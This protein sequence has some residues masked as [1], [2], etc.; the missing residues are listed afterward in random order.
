MAAD[1][2]NLE[3]FLKAQEPVYAQVCAELRAGRK[4]SHWMW[5]IFPQIEGLGHSSTARYYAISSLDE[6]KAYLD[7]P[8]LGARLRECCELVNQIEGRSIEDVF[9]Y[10]DD[11]KFRSSATLF[12]RAAAQPDVFDA[13]LEKYFGG[14]GDAA[15]VER[16]LRN[17]R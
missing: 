12:E 11:L 1:P 15:T 8:I 14:R 6:A 2:Y 9:G 5:F 10:P 13:A 3:R 17:S 4:E 16:L 7:H